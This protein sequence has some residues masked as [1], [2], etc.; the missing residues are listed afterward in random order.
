MASP[1][2]KLS[3]SGR[4]GQGVLAGTEDADVVEMRPVN[5]VVVMGTD[6]TVSVDGMDDV[7]DDT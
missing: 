7:G 3:S 4:F 1:P 6:G 2:D 5:V